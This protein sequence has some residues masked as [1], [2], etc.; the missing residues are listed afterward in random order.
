MRLITRFYG[1]DSP[2]HD[3]LLVCFHMHGVSARLEFGTKAVQQC[4]QVKQTM[5]QFDRPPEKIACTRARNKLPS[6]RVSWYIPCLCHCSLV[7]RHQDSCMHPV[8]S[9]KNKVWIR[10]LV[11]VGHNYTSISACSLVQRLT[12]I[13]INTPQ[14]I[15]GGGDTSW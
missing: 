11:K 5:V 15:G 7:P 1:M 2:P 9:S 13:C 3:R 12:C 14:I 4:F 8:V 10:S 6:W